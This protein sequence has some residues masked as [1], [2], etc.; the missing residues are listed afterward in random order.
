MHREYLFAA[1]FFVAGLGSPWAETTAS[2]R[3]APVRA[4]T[5]EGTFETDDGTPPARDISGNACRP[6]PDGSAPLLCL[7]VNDGDRFAQFA[8]VQ[9]GRLVVNATVALIGDKPSPSTLGAK[10]QALACSEGEASFTDLDGEA[11]AYATPY[12]YVIGSHGCSRRN[13]SHTVSG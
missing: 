5:V 11:V 1:T 2:L 10:P 13:R 6:A 9:D 7:V 3:L 4:I 12:F 8:T